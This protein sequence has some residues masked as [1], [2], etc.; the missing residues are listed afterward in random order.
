M[1]IFFYKLHSVK[2]S[3]CQLAQLQGLAL[4]Q[5]VLKIPV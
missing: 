3:L 1:G 5:G 4:S 2:S